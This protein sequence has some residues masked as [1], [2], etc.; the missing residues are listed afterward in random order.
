VVSYLVIL[1]NIHAISRK[2]FLNAPNYN[3]VMSLETFIGFSMNPGKRLSP[4]S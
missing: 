1:V 4:L 3:L 2:G